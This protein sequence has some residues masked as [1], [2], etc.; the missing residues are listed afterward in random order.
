MSAMNQDPGSRT[1]EVIGIR[2]APETRRTPWRVGRPGRPTIILGRHTSEASDPSS[3][4]GRCPSGRSS[5]ELIELL[6]ELLD[7][8]ADTA[9]LAVAYDDERWAAHLDYLRGL[10]RAGRKALA[11]LAA[12]EPS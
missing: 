7:A 4:A 9:Q 1:A 10:Q 5:H 3:G 2:M 8:H 6:Y 12:A 11:A